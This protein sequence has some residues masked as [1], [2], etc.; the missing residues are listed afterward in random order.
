MT[1]SPTASTPSGYD[2]ARSHLRS[3]DISACDTKPF[4]M[5]SNMRTKSS[6]FCRNT[7]VR[8]DM[9]SRGKHLDQA[10]ASKANL[11]GGPSCLATGGSW[12]KSP[13]TMSWLSDPVSKVHER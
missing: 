10:L 11:K 5:L 12:K 4:L 9:F 8:A 1:Y 3:R 6:S 7:L 2:T 13:D